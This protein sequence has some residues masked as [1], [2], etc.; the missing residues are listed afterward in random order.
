MSTEYWPIVGYG[1]EVSHDTFDPK[2]VCNLLGLDLSEYAAEDLPDVIEDI[3]DDTHFEEFLQQLVEN[4]HLVWNS[5]VNQL[6]D[7]HFY[8]HLPARL[9]WESSALEKQME[10]AD[11]KALVMSVIQPYLAD[12]Q[13][14]QT[15]LTTFDDIAAV[16]CS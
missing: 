9:P 5:T 6:D 2:K 12:G 13:D 1:I 3:L 15:I 11:V 8:I 4:T 10:R 7:N 16:G 14:S